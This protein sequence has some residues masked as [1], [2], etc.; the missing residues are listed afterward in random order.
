MYVGL[1]KDTQTF[2][3]ETPPGKA[4]EFVKKHFPGVQYSV[5]DGKTGERREEKLVA[6]P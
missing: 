3:S 5:V 6:V 4:E 1:I 2:I